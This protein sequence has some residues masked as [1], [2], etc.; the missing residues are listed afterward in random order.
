MMGFGTTEIILIFAVLGLMLL[1]VAIIIFFVVKKL[2][3]NTNS[4]FKKCPFCAE[5]IQPEAIVC[6]YCGRELVN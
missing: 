3:S 6:R 1:P 4:N 5:M 2:S